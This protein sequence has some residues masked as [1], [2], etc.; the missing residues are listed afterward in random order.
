VAS[1]PIQLE[2]KRKS[3]GCVMS[4]GCV[5]CFGLFAL[6][7]L[8]ICSITTLVVEGSRPLPGDAGRFDPVASLSAIQTVAGDDAVLTGVNASY[9]KPDGT[10]DLWA[11]YGPQV[12]YDFYRPVAAPN[13]RPI[14]AGGSASDT[15]YEA[16]AVFVSRP[17]ELR[18]VRQSGG[19]VSVRY[20][21][22]DLGIDPEPGNQSPNPPGEAVKLPACSL[23]DLWQAA[24]AQDAPANAVASIRY[25]ASG[26]LF[27]IDGT[28]F[29]LRFDE[30][31]KRV[32]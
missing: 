11:D 15:V 4:F 23:A 18:S 12:R 25:D 6:F 32:R 8:G 17:F 24:I 30:N 7:F 5:G 31:C 16:L 14:G 2:P 19:G 21:Y 1:N 22:F 13:D 26:Y 27:T 10:M 28:G 3:R 20:Q 9:V 29:S